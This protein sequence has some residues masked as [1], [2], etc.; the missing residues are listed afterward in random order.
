MK[1]RA[2]KKVLPPPEESPEPV[3]TERPKV[4]ADEALRLLD[5][6]PDFVN[7]RRFD[8]SLAV[9]VDRYPEG[10]PVRVIAQA[11][12]ISEEDVERIEAE[13]TLKLRELMRVDTELA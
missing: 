13:A 5:V 9:V 12:M 1:K 6:D 2:T 3:E 4:S 11:L 8:Y 7:L 10:C